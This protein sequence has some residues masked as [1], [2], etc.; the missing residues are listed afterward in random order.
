MKPTKNYVNGQ[1]VSSQDGDILTIFFKT[2]IVK[3]KGKYVG[4]QM[5][6]EWHFFREPGTL[7]Q[8]GNFAGGKK[9]GKWVR[10]SKDAE[11]EYD[12]EF[13]SGKLVKKN[14]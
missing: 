4:G 14:K 5:E 7:W 8:V 10:Y 9:H 3:A 13:E 11:I 2:G 1:P 12:A 6:G